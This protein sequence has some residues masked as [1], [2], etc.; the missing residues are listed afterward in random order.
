M[1]TPTNICILGIGNVLWADE[2]FGV[3]CIEALRQRFTFAPHVRLIDGGA[4]GLFLVQHAQAASH[5]M[6]FDAVDYGLAPGT[7]KL[8]E[9]EEVP[10]FLGAR[11]TAH[12]AGLQDVL[13]AAQGAGH[14]PRQMLL[15][16]CQPEV[17]DDYGGD[18]R[19]SVQRAVEKALLLSVGRLRTWGACPQPRRSAQPRYEARRHHAAAVFLNVNA[20]LVPAG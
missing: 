15:L 8:V 12:Q 7:L 4:Q 2:G 14:D 20:H 10:R 18:M 11:M 19:P 3:R 1:K 6:I 5:L 16:G 9:N 17:R 13:V